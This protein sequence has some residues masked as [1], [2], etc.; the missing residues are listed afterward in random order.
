[1]G[2]DFQT[3]DFFF[4]DYHAVYEPLL[5]GG[6]LQP[7]FLFLT[8]PDAYQTQYQSNQN[9]QTAHF[10][11]Q[12]LRWRMLTHHHFWKYYQTINHLGSAPDFWG[13]QMPF[14]CRPKHFKL[15]LLTGT[16]RFAATVR[17]FVFLSAM[18]WSTNL[19][20]RLT[21]HMSPLELQN[22]MRQ[23]TDEKAVPFAVD[24]QRR[25]L[26]KVFEFFA[27]KLKKDVYLPHLIDRRR[28]T[29]YSIVNLAKFEGEIAHYRSSDSTAKQMPAADRA[30]LHAILHGTSVS[31]PELIK[32]EN[33][34]KFLLTY[35]IDPD[36]AVTYFD[37]GTLIFMQRKALKTN[38]E[39]S[40][41]RRGAMRCH[42]S[43]LRNYLAMT[44]LL[45]RF[46]SDTKSYENTEKGQQ[47]IKSLRADI[48]TVLRS[49]PHWYTNPF[50]Q[51]FHYAY[52][53]LQSL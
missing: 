11:I 6:G 35:F 52:G 14:I 5:S 49:I 43:N 32:R 20:I 21:G 37:Y 39:A 18:G 10:D 15:S 46:Y 33:N 45:S 51:S 34:K 12:P 30:A 23:L 48:K 7:D 28:I 4:F 25:T 29:R 24:G 1:M 9:I 27:E 40:K 8:E 36:F 50:C 53:P 41:S 16:D 17:S 26:P 42:S 38:Y 19:E 44:L 47:R 13:L 3:V 22:F 31:V 2:Y